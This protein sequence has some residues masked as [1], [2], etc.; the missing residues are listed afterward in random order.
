MR[1]ISWSAVQGAYC[2]MVLIYLR[3]FYQHKST[4]PRESQNLSEAEYVF[5][6]NEGFNGS[7]IYHLIFGFNLS[8]L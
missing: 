7:Y 4:V 8:L 3:I 2:S 6:K 5:R 1:G